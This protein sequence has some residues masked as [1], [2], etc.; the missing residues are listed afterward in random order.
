M[1]KKLGEKLV[2][3]KNISAY[4][5]SFT[6]YLISQYSG[7][8]SVYDIYTVTIRVTGNFRQFFT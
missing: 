2:F 3:E 6:S 1:F 4:Q 7:Y 5:Y 8:G